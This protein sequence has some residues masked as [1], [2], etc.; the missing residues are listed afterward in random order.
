MINIG[1]W[2][3]ARIIL[4][5]SRGLNLEAIVLLSYFLMLMFSVKSKKIVLFISLCRTTAAFM[6]GFTAPSLALGNN[7]NV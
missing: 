3:A 7:C 4:F 5:I 6:C 2:T 1:H